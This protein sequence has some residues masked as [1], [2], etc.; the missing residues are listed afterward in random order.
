[1]RDK[2][3][4]ILGGGIAGLVF[5]LA[6]AVPSI[7][8]P[9]VADEE[10]FNTMLKTGDEIIDEPFDAAGLMKFDDAIV[11]PWVSTD[12]VRERTVR[13]I[14]Y[15]RTSFVKIITTTTGTYSTDGLGSPYISY[16]GIHRTGTQGGGG[17]FVAILSGDGWTTILGQ[18]AG[19]FVEIGPI[20]IAPREDGC[21]RDE[22]ATY[23]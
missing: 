8:P 15:G 12:V 13:K 22:D 21:V 5:A 3:K 19:S 9:A 17:G 2:T 11:E 6:L 16:P 18:N 20:V 1:M 7:L 10:P 4:G 23:C 14:G